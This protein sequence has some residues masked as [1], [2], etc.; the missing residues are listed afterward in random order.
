MKAKLILS[1]FI[2]L[3]FINPGIC[4]EKKKYLFT[5]KDLIERAIRF[6]PEINES[7]MEV[8]IAKSYLSKVKAFYY[9]Q[10]KIEAVAG[11]VSDADEPIVRRVGRTNI[12]KIHDPYNGGYGIFGRLDFNIVQPLFTFG[13]LYNSKQAAFYGLRAKRYE[14][15]KK[16]VEI[17]F[18]IKQ[19]YYALAISKEG[20]GVAEDT[21]SFFLDTK[22][23]IRKLL[24][25]KSENVTESDLY[26]VDA[27]RAIA[28]KSKAE[29]ERGMKVAYFALKSLI[30][31]SPEEEFDIVKVDLSINKEELKD[32]S[33][34][35]NQALANRP[36]YRQLKEAI[37]AKRFEVKAAISEKYPTFFAAIKGSVAGAPGREKFD[38]KYIP[39][40]FNHAYAGIVFG[41]EWEFD[42]GIKNA[43]ID[44]KRAEFRRLE[45]MKKNA[46]LNIPIQIA[47]LYHQLIELKKEAEFYR[48]AAISA[49]KWVV[50]ALQEFDMGI[51]TAENLLFGIEKYGQNQ[52]KYLEALYKY[53]ITMAQLKA[54]IGTW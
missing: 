52:G 20:V 6:N 5:L 54:A 29:A 26:K 16:K 17:A 18:R 41:M 8:Y 4:K 3:S 11:P 15:L 28:L 7:K 1:I 40:E 9:P 33:Y 25:M 46:E 45:F 51:G 22:K 32:L 53:H 2:C 50:S 19:L 37:E 48:K 10:I 12:W 30:G 24:K 31:L 38:N 36:D 42:F 27:Y 34:Y 13:K 39:D 23:I 49:R 21:D 44:E 47:D 43:K 35:I 14:V